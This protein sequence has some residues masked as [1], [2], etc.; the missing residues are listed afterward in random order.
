MKMNH[1]KLGLVLAFTT[2]LVSSHLLAAPRHKTFGNRNFATAPKPPGNFGGIVSPQAKTWKSAPIP[3]Y[4][5]FGDWVS[6]QRKHKKAPAIPKVKPTKP[7][8][9][10]APTST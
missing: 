4:R 10:P 8:P 7:K 6:S 5:N 2:M 3:G 9:T 1:L